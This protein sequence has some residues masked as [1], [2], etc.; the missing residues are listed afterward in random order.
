[1]F[2]SLVIIAEIILLVIVL[3]TD[4]AQY[5][6]ADVQ[7]SVSTWLEDIAKIPEQKAL[8]ELNKQVS[9]HFEAMRPFQ[10]NYINDILTSKAKVRHFHSLY[11]AKDDKN[12]YIYGA[13]LRFFCSQIERSSLLKDD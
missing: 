10:K 11:C 8:N 7:Q 5:L 12:P 1:M 4:F 9:P 2:R 6:F 3:R 13:S